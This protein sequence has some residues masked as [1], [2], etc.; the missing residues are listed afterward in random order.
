MKCVCV[1]GEPD[2]CVMVMLGTLPYYLYLCLRS[3]ACKLVRLPMRCCRNFA[4][5]KKFVLAS[6]LSSL[7]RAIRTYCLLQW[8]MHEHK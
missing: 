7:P 5:E 8:A 3:C 4:V 2:N 1:G 6:R